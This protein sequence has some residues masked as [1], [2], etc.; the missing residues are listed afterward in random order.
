MYVN[1][2]AKPPVSASSAEPADGNCLAMTTRH[3]PRR[4]EYPRHSKVLE[5]TVPERGVRGYKGCSR[6]HPRCARFMTGSSTGRCRNDV[7]TRTPDL[8]REIKAVRSFFLF[9]LFLFFPRRRHISLPS[10]DASLSFLFFS[11]PPP[12]CREGG[13]TCGVKPA[14]LHRSASLP[15]LPPV[16]VS[17]LVVFGRGPVCR[18]AGRRHGCAAVPIKE[19][20]SGVPMAAEDGRKVGGFSSGLA[21]LLSGEDKKGKAQ[22]A[23]LVS[24]CDD[25]RYQSV[26]H[27][28]EHVFDLPSKSVTTSKRP[29]DVDFVRSIIKNQRWN[30]ELDHN[31]GNTNRE[32]LVV[33]DQGCG[34]G[35]VSLDETSICGELRAARQPLQVESFAM[36]SSARANACVSRGKWMYEVVLETSGVQQLGWATLMCPFT[37]RKGVGDADDSYAFDGRRVRKWNKEA[38]PYGQPWVVGDVIGCC[39]DLGE[40]KISFYRNGISLGV[41]FEGIRRNGAELSYY[42]AVSLSEGERCNLNFGSRPFKYLVDG[43]LPLQSP[44]SSSLLATY[45]LRSFSRLMELQCLDKSYSASFERLRRLK[46]FSLLEEQLFHSI[47]HGICEELFSIV[48][49]SESTAEYISWGSLLSFLLE[50]FG[51]QA[52]HDCLSLDRVVGLFVE[53]SGSHILFRHL[54]IALS[55]NCRIAPLVLMECPFTGS[56]PYLAL[57][58]HILKH[59]EL[60]ILWWK[61]AD[62]EYS[63]EGFLSRKGPNKQDLQSLIPSV[64][65]PGSSEDMYVESSMM[66]TTTALSGAFN[67]VSTL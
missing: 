8:P 9:L 60:M 20:N 24:C 57:A 39:I 3:V 21:V 54:I 41:A 23:H 37:D 36:F 19:E 26:E 14:R 56:Y 5:R 17:L 38:K 34:P 15:Y 46:R 55:A 58:C 1:T 2:P 66:L 11:L 30:Y 10:S 65:R 28:L 22:K 25:I 6:C 61:L 42:P 16:L 40:G 33:K 67:K 27:M 29:V 51:S 31:L 4:K 43:F 18:R 35:I 7:D 13:A 62:Y 49:T 48:G 53:F 59:E 50:L 63:L 12:R 45:L 44:P 32:G 47:C 52:P 64:W